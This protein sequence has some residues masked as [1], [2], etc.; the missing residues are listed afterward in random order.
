MVIPNAPRFLR[1][2]DRI[3]FQSKIANLT[4]EKLHGF[5][6]LELYDAVSG[7][8]IA[9]ELLDATKQTVPFT[10]DGSGNT[11]VAWELHI[12]EGLQAV[13]YKVLAKAGDFTDGEESILP[14]LTNRM[15]V[16]ESI[17]LTVRSNTE[18]QYSFQKLKNPKTTTQKNHQLTLEYT[19]NPAWPALQSL[20]YLMEFPHECAEQTFSRYYANTLGAHILNSN[21]NVKAVFETW[22]GDGQLTSKLEQN[23]ALKQ[24]LIAET[25]WVRDAQSEA[26]RKK[27]LGLL[28]NLRKLQSQQHRVFRKLKQLQKNSGG[29]PWFRGGDENYYITR[30]IITGFG[31]LKQ[32]DVVDLENNSK[33]MIEKAVRYID[34]EF[35]KRHHHRLQ[36]RKENEIYVSNSDIHYLYARSFYK[37][38]RF[39]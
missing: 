22:E 14:V 10:I 19:T 36:Y 13:Q 6:K 32:L 11:V 33:A 23:E 17:P 9:Q 37:K 7:K 31:H 2:N 1:E 27:R 38:I 3:V 35:Q 5:A 28:F 16:T 4:P 20:P 18:K 15:L 39:R 34:T 8:V 21:P 29:F 30:H 26:I 12:P 24:V 25:P